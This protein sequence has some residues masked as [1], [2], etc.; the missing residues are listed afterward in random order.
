MC[1]VSVQASVALCAFP[2]LEECALCFL[3]LMFPLLVSVFLLFLLVDVLVYFC[4]CRVNGKT[5]GF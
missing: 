3:G 1:V 5:Q 2:T 4:C